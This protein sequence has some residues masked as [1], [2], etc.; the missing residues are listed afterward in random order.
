MTSETV[1]TIAVSPDLAQ[2]LPAD[3]GELAE[4][5]ALGLK[6]W[7]IEQALAAFRDGRGTLAYAAEQ[8]GISLR[9]MIALAYAHGLQP[10]I[11][12]SQVAH[13]PLTLDQ[14]SNL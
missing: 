8:A 9:E 5:L 2:Q 10:R 11:D 14:A 1:V 4:V 6:S 7:R 13:Q 12:D 3:A